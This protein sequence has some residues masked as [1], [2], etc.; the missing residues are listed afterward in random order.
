MHTETTFSLRWAGPTEIP[1]INERYAG[2]DFVLSGPGDRIAVAEADGEPA[3]LGRVVPL[4]PGIGELGG[5][6]V[7]ERY[8]GRGLAKRLVTFLQG[9]PEFHTLYCL[10]FA[11]LESLYAG[12]GF[13][14]SPLT[15]DVPP[16]VAEKYRWCNEH[17]GRPVLLMRTAI[18]I[19][20]K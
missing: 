19:R 4:A 20:T 1:W 8:Q 9:R 12:L 6:L 5:M 7:F 10:P 18:P 2:V 11:E 3:G 15:E 17:Y 14:R 13:A 16:Y